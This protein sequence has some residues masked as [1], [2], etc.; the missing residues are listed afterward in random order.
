[1]GSFT[2]V[3]VSYMQYISRNMHTL[4]PHYLPTPL[5][6]RGK[7]KRYLKDSDFSIID[8]GFARVYWWNPDIARAAAKEL[9]KVN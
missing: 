6:C 5:E 2:Q 8:Q 4:C 3:Y 7:G 9:W 1:M